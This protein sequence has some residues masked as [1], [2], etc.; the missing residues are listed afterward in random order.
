MNKKYIAGIQQIGVGV[1]D[2]DEAFKWYAQNF[3]MDCI[4]FK[5]RAVAELMLPYTEGKKRERYALLAVNMQGGGG[6]EIWQHTGKKPQPPEFQAEIGDL[7]I[8]A[9]KLKTNQIEKA[10]N[11]FKQKKLNIISEIASDPVGTKFF[12]V[13]DPYGNIFQ[14]V[15]EENIYMP[16]RNFN[17]GVYGAIIGVSN[18]DKALKVYHDIL[19]YDTIVYDKTDVFDD[20]SSLPGS[21]QTLRRVL[22]KHSKTRTGSLAPLFGPTCI[23]L[24]GNK[25]VEKR[26]I[27]E[28][29]IWGDPGFIHLCFDVIG[30]DKLREE[31]SS[32]GYPFTVDSAESFDMGEA[33]GHF[34][35]ISDPDETPIEF[36]ETH[37]VPI[38]K[39]IG[40]YMN[41]KGRN[42]E[43]SLP[44]WMMSTLKW[45]RVKF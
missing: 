15:E 44:R 43:K 1:T 42:P 27:F 34:A 38:I 18:I 3:G 19:E 5:E 8:F 14:L 29:R 7:G 25:K 28:G 12:F 22:L 21:K 11:D 35:Y 23:E 4:A 39:S 17:G 36:V 41:L 9:A 2:V 30:I 16:T 40:W 24:A 37:K 10:Y 13:K 6:F 32:K 31:V 33:A 45:K 20:F 26:K